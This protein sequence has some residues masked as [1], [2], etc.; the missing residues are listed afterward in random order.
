MQKITD[1]P[2][3]HTIEKTWRQPVNKLFYQWHWQSNLKHKEIA[4]RL[5]IP[6]PTITRWFK[7]LGIPT[8]SGTRFTNMNLLNIGPRKTPP[9]KPKVRKPRPWKV[10]TEFFNTWSENVAYVLGFF[11]ADG[12]IFTNPRGSHYLSLN[13]TDKDLL[14]R[15]KDLLGSGHKL[16]LKKT[17]N[18]HWKPSWIIQI[19]S[20]KIFER[21]L[22]LGI[23]PKKAYRVKIP[24][25]P[26][27]YIADFI[28]GYFD[29]DGHIYFGYNHK[30]D[31]QL[32]TP[33]LITG[34]TSCNKKIL[35]DIAAKIHE[36]ADT[37][38][39]KPTFSDGAFRIQY[40]TH[41][42][43]KIYL[44]FYSNNPSLYLVRKKIV[45][46]KYLET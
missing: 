38:L 8:Q 33:V 42:S 24:D 7:Y 41:D 17:S 31:R 46:E 26:K 36:L 5:N 43:R 16:S 37:R 28:R 3:I 14:I 9:A 44:F 2:R 4:E 45:F 32:P 39:R 11:C 20:K 40:S 6:R 12:Y 35:I 22:S 19:G 21:F 15:L 25:I 1:S 30:N 18:D 10:N 23:T 34:F 13:I 27:E 29:G